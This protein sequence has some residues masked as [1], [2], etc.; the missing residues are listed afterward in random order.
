MKL[1]QPSTWFAKEPYPATAVAA[2]DPQPKPT[3]VIVS[4]ERP[5]FGMYGEGFARINL[6]ELARRKTLDIYAKMRLDEQ[7]KAVTTFKRDAIISRGWTF[8]Y[9]E[10]SALSEKER[11]ARLKVLNKC[12]EELSIGFVDALNV[13]STGRDFGF[14]LTE[15]VYKQLVCEGKAYQGLESLLGRDP[16]TFEFFTDPFG[17]LLKCEQEAAG[18]RISIDLAKFVHY[19]HNPEFDYY[20]G[21]SDL[22]EAY[23]SWYFKDTMIRYWGLYMEK[24]GGGLVVAS[25]SP[26]AN[27]QGGSEAYEELQ[28]ALTQVKASASLLLPEG[29]TAQVVFPTT[30]DAFEKAC[31]YHD[32]A[33]AK[34][35]LVPNLMGVSST[36]TTGAYAQ[37]QTQLETFAWTLQADAKRLEACVDRQIFRDLQDQ[38]WGDGEYA[39]FVFKPLSTEKLRWLIE[40]WTKLIGAKAVITTEQDEARLREILEM[41]PRDPKAKPLID[42]EVETG[43]E[44]EVGMKDKEH[45]LGERS[46][47]ADKDR[48]FEDDKRRATDPVLSAAEEKKAKEKAKFGF[49]P[50]QPRDDEGQWTDDGGG[51]RGASNAGKPLEIGRGS[52]ISPAAAKKLTIQQATK[53]LEERGLKVEPLQPRASDGF[54]PRY[55]VTDKNGSSKEVS[56]DEIK[57]L[58]TGGKKAKHTSIRDAR[59]AIASARER[60]DFA[61]IDKKQA[62]AAQALS[63]ELSSIVATA[64]HREMGDDAHLAQ[65]TDEEVDDIGQVQLHPVAVGKLKV[66]VQKALAESWALGAEHAAREVRKTKK[67]VNLRFADLRGKAASYFESNAFMVAGDV[68]ERARSVIQQELLTSVKVGRSPSQTRTAIWERLVAKG[69]S[70]RESVRSVES[71]EAVIEALNDL[72]KDTEEA[73]AAYLDTVART[74]LFAAMNEARYAEFTDPALGDFVVALRYSAV[75][76]EHT[77]DICT[78]LHEH[79]YLTGN[80]LWDEYRPPNHFNCRSIL[81]PITQL[82]MEDGAWDGEESDTPSVEPQEGFGG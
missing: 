16:K 9:A 38:N 51:E 13:I 45:E 29:V 10:D 17:R 34:A 68:S 14:S 3:N 52:S 62:T 57:G 70:S 80:P 18:R 47:D 55:R 73:A 71:D 35:L 41:P 72:W 36:G 78:A 44:H 50:D 79:V 5:Q 66:K 11:A 27:I 54:K 8:E 77:T 31:T 61:V 22:R 7:V 24:L 82:D 28:R 65:L 53:K 81:V 42:P 21:R 37:S 32:L 1:F 4:V 26:E 60:V 46:K 64:V 75:L 25:I 40:T 20:F 15:K 12:I 23:R 39:K 2:P 56:A 33:I 48:N 49:N 63:Q 43:R 19:V 58:L 59:L 74:N 69:L 76:D 30:S 6:D 67:V